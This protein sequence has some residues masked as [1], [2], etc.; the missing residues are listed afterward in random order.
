VIIVTLACGSMA[1]RLGQSQVIDEIVAGILLG[2]SAFG[3]FAPEAAEAFLPPMASFEILST[4]GL[5]LFLSLSG[6]R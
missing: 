1:R 4:V 6:L 2:S 5:I 3:R